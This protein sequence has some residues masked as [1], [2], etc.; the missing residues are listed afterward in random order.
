V[1]TPLVSAHFVAKLTE[2]TAALIWLEPERYAI[3][4]AVLTES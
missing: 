4:A 1:L 2:K 3:V